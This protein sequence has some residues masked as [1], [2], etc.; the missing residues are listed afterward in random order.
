M[1]ERTRLISYLLYG[2]FS[3]ILKKDTI[4]TPK[5]SFHICLGALRLSLSL[6]LKKYLDA[7]F[8]FSYWKYSCTL[9]IF[10]VVF[11]HAHVVLLKRAVEP[12]KSFIM[13]GHYKKM[14]PA[15]QPIRVRVLLWFFYCLQ[16][17]SSEGSYEKNCCWWQPEQKSFSES[18][19][20]V[21]ISRYVLSF[22]TL[23]L[24]CLLNCL[25]SSFDTAWKLHIKLRRIISL[26]D[27]KFSPSNRPCH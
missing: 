9:S 7:S 27:R 13:P 19:E 25:C 2:L 15:Q 8:S 24:E 6:I 26:C 10:S 11:A 5:V 4:K 14:M 21:I 22:L 18:S 23:F 20:K 17:R 1:T 12:R 16:V 3:A